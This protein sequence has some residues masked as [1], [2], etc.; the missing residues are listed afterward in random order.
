LKTGEANQVV[1]SPNT[2]LLPNLE[3]AHP[4]PVSLPYLLKILLQEKFYSKE[5]TKLW[6]GGPSQLPLKTQVRA[7]VF[8]AVQTS[9]LL[10]ACRGHST[11][12][13][14]VLE[15]AIAR[16]LFPH[17]PEK[18]VRVTCSVALSSRP[19]LPEPIT[20][21]SMGVWVQELSETYSRK[22]VT[23]ETFPWKEAQRS[24]QTIRKELALKSKN[25]SVGLF[26]YVGKFR[27][28]LC[29]SKIGKSRKSTF[30]VSSLGV[31]KTENSE[32]SSIPQM[33]R[34]IFTQSASVTGSA[35]EFS[36]ITGADGC[37][38]LGISWQTGV[39]ED[40]K[41]QAIIETLGKELHQLCA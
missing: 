24:R 28:D 25:T 40:E 34:V 1:T 5:D 9:A 39:V 21:D 6:A 27:D 26:K 35:V 30:E 29:L 17:I 16:S 12:V 38:A 18:F 8:T 33:G 10:T 41:V 11:T 13:T 31:V 3:A 22:A 14:C 23:Q 15:T 2:P 7:I 36:V 19:W 32:D 20:D 37:L 4:L